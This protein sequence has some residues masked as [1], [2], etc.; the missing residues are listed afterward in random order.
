MYKK[1]IANIKTQGA[2]PV[3][4][5]QGENTYYIEKIIK[6][7]RE[8]F[9]EEV[10]DMNIEKYDASELSLQS[11]INIANTQSFFSTEKVILVN[12][13]TWFNNAKKGE[14]KAIDY[15]PLIDYLANPNLGTV[16]VMVASGKVNQAR[17]VIKE[18]DAIGGLFSFDKL[19]KNSLVGEINNAFKA[20]G[21]V[22]DKIALETLCL[23]A[24]DNLVLIEKEIEKLS[25][26]CAEEKRVTLDDVELLVAES[27]NSKIYDLTDCI[28]RG[29]LRA[30]MEL[31]DKLLQ[32]ND[33]GLIW[34]ALASHY[35]LIN[36]AVAMNEVGANNKEI[37]EQAGVRFPFIIEKAIRQ[38]RRYSK[39]TRLSSLTILV[40]GE[41][42]FKSGKVEGRLSLEQTVIKLIAL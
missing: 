31:I 16:V 42:N 26:Y 6:F 34:G 33:S 29:D 12:N 5:L 13:V 40:E 10:D 11:L 25:L 21:L 19:D 28:A 30:S 36:L 27:N 22:I 39:K 4:L 1:I 14:T 38:G 37:M 18:I 9:L 35:R 3:Y 32:V 24:E 2:L 23:R 15:E 7:F 8:D 41:E 17:K 20:K